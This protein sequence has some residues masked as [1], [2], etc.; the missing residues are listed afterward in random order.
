MTSASDF[1]KLIESWGAPFVAR[2]SIG[3]FSGGLVHRR[4]IANLDA[5]GKGPAGKFKIGRKVGYPVESVVEWLE[6]R[7]E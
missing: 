1:S 3:K 2:E 5:K 4:T 7:A 6:N